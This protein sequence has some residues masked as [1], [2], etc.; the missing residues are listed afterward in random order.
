M[1]VVFAYADTDACLVV[2]AAAGLLTGTHILT[3]LWCLPA[4]LSVRFMAEQAREVRQMDRAL[5]DAQDP[6]LGNEVEG[7]CLICS[8]VFGSQDQD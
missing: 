8:Q 7:T 2:V 6:L 3:F 1:Q 4:G 5:A